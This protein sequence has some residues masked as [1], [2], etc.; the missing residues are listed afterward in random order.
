MLICYDLG[1]AGDG[2]LPCLGRCRHHLFPDMG[3]AAIGDDDIGVQALRVRA[4]ENLSGWSSRSAAAA[5]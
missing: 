2:A 3:G 1:G 4:A 5:P